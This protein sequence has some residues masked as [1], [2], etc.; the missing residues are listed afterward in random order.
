MFRTTFLKT[1]ILLTVAATAAPFCFAQEEAADLSGTW[2]WERSFNDNVMTFTIELTQDDKG[3]LSGTYSRKRGD[4]ASD[5]VDLDDLILDG[6]KLKFSVTRTRNDRT[7]TSN[8]EGVVS[9]DSIKGVS[10]RTRNGEERESEWIAKR[11]GKSGPTW[12]SLFDGKTLEGWE[13]VGNENS[14]WVVE[15]GAMTATGL[16]SMLVNTSGPY[17]NF[18]FRAECKISDG[19]NSGL[20]FRTTRKPGFSDGYEAQV[21]STHS[22]PIRTGSLYGMCHVYKRHVEPDM[23]FTYDLEVRDD[24]W[25]GRK[26]TRIKITVDGNELYEYMDFELTFKEGHFAFQHHD[27]RSIVHIRKVEVMPLAD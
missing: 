23:W 19:G 17:K 15:D 4:N 7:F 13:R 24:V 1:C 25:R 12:I 26:M 27:P 5:P 9:A 16:A 2:T 22:D 21:D 20:Y 18:R 8:Y 3:K 6:N 10:K 11:V 14:K